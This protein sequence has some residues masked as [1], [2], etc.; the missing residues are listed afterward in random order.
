MTSIDADS[1]SSGTSSGHATDAHA[2]GTGHD[3]P[4]ICSTQMFLGILGILLFLT[5]IT[6]AVSRFDFGGANM[7]IAM[8]VASLKASLVIAIF[9]HMFWDTATNR[10]FFL[11]SFLFLGLLFLFIFADFLARGDLVKSHARVA[12]I[13][14]TLLKENNVP[15]SAEWIH[16]QHRLKALEGK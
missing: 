1:A 2:E 13:D 10:I 9:M 8:G 4:H 16:I 15:G 14:P 12:P 6:V 3:G 11:T 5:F 7:W